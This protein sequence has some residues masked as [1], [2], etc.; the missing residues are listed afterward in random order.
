MAFRDRCWPRP[1]SFTLAKPQSFAGQ[2]Q[3]KT[4]LVGIL[5]HKLIDQIRRHGREVSAT[6]DDDQEDTPNDAE[7]RP[8]RAHDLARSKPRASSPGARTR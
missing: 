4:W 5:K 8:T 6:T 2:S 1:S 7:L 3:L